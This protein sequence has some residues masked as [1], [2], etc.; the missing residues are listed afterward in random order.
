MFIYLI[1]RIP[2]NSFY[3]QVVKKKMMSKQIKKVIVLIIKSVYNELA[4]HLYYFDT[5]GR[6]VFKQGKWGGIAE[7]SFGNR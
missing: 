6:G 5:F 1:K 2:E 3:F 4:N 7:Y